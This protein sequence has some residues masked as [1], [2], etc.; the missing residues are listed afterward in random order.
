[1]PRF[2]DRWMNKDPLRDVPMAHRLDPQGGATLGRADE[3]Y[4]E[5]RERWSSGLTEQEVALGLK[6]EASE[7]WVY[8]TLR[9]EA[10]CDDP[11]GLEKRVELLARVKE[12]Q[13]AGWH[14]YRKGEANPYNPLQ[15]PVMHMLPAL[16]VEMRREKTEK[17]LIL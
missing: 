8:R 1:M 6:N 12:M 16:W 3:D 5:W 15:A 14:I 13:R 2:L 7:P 10:V 4:R 9:C 11:D 17:E